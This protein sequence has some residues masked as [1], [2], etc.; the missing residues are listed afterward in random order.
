LVDRV[1]FPRKTGLNLPDPGQ[2]KRHQAEGSLAAVCS[3]MA[4]CPIS[5]AKTKDA[6]S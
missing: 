2:L 3:G 4:C 5:L 6:P 1:G